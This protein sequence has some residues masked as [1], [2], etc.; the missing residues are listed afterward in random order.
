MVELE[1]KPNSDD[2]QQERY[3]VR[4]SQSSAQIFA[5]F[6]K[7]GFQVSFYSRIFESYEDRKMNYF[8]Q[9]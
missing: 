7:G 2:R 6:L 5:L 8:V 3:N 9:N 4:L 1:F